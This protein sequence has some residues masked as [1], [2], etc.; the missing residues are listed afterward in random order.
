[1]ISFEISLCKNKR[2]VLVHLC[3]VVPTAPN[4][5]ALR[6]NSGSASGIT[7]IPLLPPNSS[8]ERPS[9]LETAPPILRPILQEPVAEIKGALLSCTNISPT[10]LLDPTKSDI[11]PFHPNGSKT[12]LTIFWIA[13]AVSGVLEDG[14]QTMTSPQ[15]AAIIAFQAQT[16]PG[17][18]KAVTIPTIPKGCHCSYILWFGRSEC[19]VFP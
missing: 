4:T 10:S 19:I 2:L 17:K 7:I 13:I 16:A 8:N 14:F 3:P 6:T 1:M 12:R 15:T 11:T 9:L 5:T 18:L